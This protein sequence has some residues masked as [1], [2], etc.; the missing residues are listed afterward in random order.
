MVVY[1]YQQKINLYTNNSN[2]CLY[3]HDLAGTD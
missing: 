3:V 2:L 1:Y